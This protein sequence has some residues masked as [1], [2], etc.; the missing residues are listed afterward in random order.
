LASF[1]ADWVTFHLS[2]GPK[3]MKQMEEAR[4]QEQAAWEWVGVSVLTSFS[5]TEY[6]D[7]QGSKESTTDLISRWIEGALKAGIGTFV[8]SAQE[9]P[10]LGSRFPD[11]KWIVPG[12]RFASDAPGD[13]V[14]VQTPLEALRLGAD[15]IVM[16]R[17]LTGSEAGRAKQDLLAELSGQISE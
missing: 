2:A 4:I 1:P 17:S 5:G 14:R 10:V 13:Q 12:I 16:G 8:C 15:W 11:A 6:V 3:A 9:L 7:W